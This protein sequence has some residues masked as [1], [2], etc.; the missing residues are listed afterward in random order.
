MVKSSALRGVLPVILVPVEEDYSIDFATLKR[1]VDWLFDCSVDGVVL[2]MVSEIFR[3]T[4]EERDKL[5]RAVVSATK[6]RGPVIAS[7]GAESIP[8]LL[9]NAKSAEAS[10]ASALMAIPPA[11]TSCLPEEI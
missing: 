5:V 8:Q 1:E 9:R 2:A 7:V 6:G 4:D 3:F 11:M 10:G